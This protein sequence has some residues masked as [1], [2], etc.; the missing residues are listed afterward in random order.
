LK[1]DPPG[2]PIDPALPG[3]TTTPQAT[4]QTPADRLTVW[5]MTSGLMGMFAKTK[6]KTLT[7]TALLCLLALHCGGI[8]L[9]K[10]FGFGF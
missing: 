4:H 5:Q 6:N 3:A 2:I 8:C 10:H 9:L 1:V 7:T